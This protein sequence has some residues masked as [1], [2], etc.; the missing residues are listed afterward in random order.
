MRI[1]DGWR[2]V[3]VAAASAIL[4]ATLAAPTASA[5]PSLATLAAA[6]RA[7]PSEKVLP[8]TTDP[9]VQQVWTGVDTVELNGQKGCGNVGGDSANIS[10]EVPCT[11]GDRTA[12]RSVVVVGDSM[13]GAWVPAFDLWGQAQHWKVV[14]LVK[15]GCPPWTTH[16]TAPQCLAFRAFEVRTINALRPNAVFAVGLQDRGQVTME[17][18]KPSLVAATIIGFAKEVRPSRAKVFVPQNTPW[19]FGIG[20]PLNC[21]VTNAGNIHTCNRDARTRVVESAMLHGIGLAAADHFVTE[22][23]VDQLFCTAT[24]C[25]VLVG[26]HIVYA[27]DHHFSTVWAEYISAAFATIFDPLL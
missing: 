22:V 9:P 15:D 20:S 21:L 17:T 13:A 18:T 26:D 24:I 16:I 27:D 5:P 11:F 10:S 23:P 4:L 8:T 19:F 25:P 14:R 2:V 1:S 6:L 7:A 12:S 3:A